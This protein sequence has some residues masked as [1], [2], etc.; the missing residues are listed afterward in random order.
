MPGIRSISRLVRH[1]I[2]YRRRTVGLD[3]DR[4]GSALGAVQDGRHQRIDLVI[5][6]IAPAEMDRE[7]FGTK[8]GA[9]LDQGVHLGDRIGP[10]TR[11]ESKASRE[12]P[13]RTLRLA[14]H[15]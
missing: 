3:V 7:A 1:R 4:Q 5:A 14:L 13:V 11:G 15:A 10:A 12:D 2:L 9:A 6:L 8:G